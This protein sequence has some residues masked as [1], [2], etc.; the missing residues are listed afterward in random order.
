MESGPVTFPRGFPQRNFE[1]LSLVDLLRSRSLNQANQIAYT[2][3]R[4][5]D[6][7]EINLT[8][9]ELDQQ[10]RAIAATL[11]NVTGSG[12][13]A[14]LLYPPGLEFIAAFFGCLY[15]GV[16]AVPAYPA[17]NI[18]GVP[19][20]RAIVKDGQ[21]TLAMTTASIASLAT[22]LLAQA[23]DLEALVWLSSDTV[24]PGAAEDWKQHNATGSDLA[25]LQYTSGSTGTPKGVM[26]SHENLLQNADL[27][28][29]AVEHT[30]HDRYVSWL[31][32]FHDMGFMAGVL[33]PL[34]AGIPAV[35]MSPVSFLQRPLQ[36]LQAIS[37]YKGTT[38]GGPNF[39]YDL[40]ARKITEEQ[41]QELDLRSWSVAFNG[42]EPIRSETLDRFVAAF[43]PCGFRRGTFYPC[44]GLAEATLIVSG[45]RKS[46]EP[47]IKKLGSTALA[48]GR[49]TEPSGAGDDDAR[50]MVGC[51]KSLGAQEVAIVGPET[52]T[53]RLPGEVGEIWVSGRSVAQGY[54][55][56]PEETARV[57]RA[58]I[59]GTDDG[60][61]LRTGDL[62]FVYD[63]ELFV[64]GRL[65]DLIIIRGRNHYPQDIE[66]TVERTHAALR[67]GCGAAFSIDVA[68]EERL[69]VVQEVELRHQPDLNE[70][71]GRI[72]QR[73]AENHELQLYAVSIIKGGTIPKTSS[74]KIQR[75]AS[76]AAF[77]NGTLECISEWRA[78][79]SLDNEPDAACFEGGVQRAEDVEAW[80][81][82]QLAA[83]LKLASSDIDVNSPIAR[84]GVDSLMD[85]ELVHSAEAELGVT[86]PVL[87]FLQ[88]ASVSELAS[89][90]RSQL[91]Q[92]S[93]LHVSS[94]AAAQDKQSEYTLSRGQQALWFLHSLAPDSAAYNIGG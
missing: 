80:L 94:L 23:P 21:A 27:V 76:K 64:A 84:Y 14:L 28:Y 89:Q 63:G 46:D 81:V 57:F 85:I 37:K 59:A 52:F 12:A 50:E 5:G 51:G 75:H 77:V 56:R 67:P 88:G 36:W 42:A 61:Y 87:S 92:P 91:K 44:Y 93:T 9:R 60:P 8:Y 20:L 73:V 49:A 39:A 17:R 58:R 78:T 4:E 79:E 86:L 55:N 10:A 33:E 62:G 25:F 22:H 65:K 35:L 32:T 11:Q 66:L 90:V 34:Y 45:G 13:R 74:G 41:K 29:H 38:S 53:R 26:L 3:L 83:K 1:S 70:V 18:R 2:F 54:W 16:V 31:P 82:S 43:A 19:R 48:H 24:N 15:A 7:A 72:R 68:G 71:I 69:V 30:P 6:A 47:L 40:C